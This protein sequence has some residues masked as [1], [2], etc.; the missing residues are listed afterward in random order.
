MQLQLFEIEAGS[1][2][3]PT[4]GNME[5]ITA[6]QAVQAVAHTALNGGE[7]EIYVS[8][9][10]DRENPP[11]VGFVF[12]GGVGLSYGLGSDETKA[13]ESEFEEL[14]CGEPIIGF[15]YNEQVV[16]DGGLVDFFTRAL[17]CKIVIDESGNQTE[18][19]R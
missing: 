3:L 19:Q 12:G 13:F 7:I 17:A 11:L 4:A 1:K 14:F 9:E 16:D 5:V 8:D 10:A 18:D 15:D 2:P 6:E